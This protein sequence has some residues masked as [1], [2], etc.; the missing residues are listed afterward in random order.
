MLT[1][2]IGALWL[3]TAAEAFAHTPPTVYQN[4]RVDET[5]AVW[6]A[7]IGAELFE[8]WLG[9]APKTLDDLEEEERARVV[10]AVEDFFADWSVLSIDRVP[11]KGVLKGLETMEFIDHMATWRYG[12]VTLVY[13]TIGR[14]R[15]MS[16]VWK[17]F[18]NSIGW[19][20]APIQGEIS[21]FGRGAYFALAEKEPEFVWHV[22]R[23]PRAPP[24]FAPPAA[25]EK[26]VLDLPVASAAL[27]A[28]G[29]LAVPLLLLGKASGKITAGVAVGA[30]VLAAALSGVARTEVS[31]P[32]DRAFEMPDEEGARFLFETIQKNIYRA[33]EYD[34]EEDVYDTLAKSVRGHLLEDV[35]AE[36]MESLIFRE[37]GGG[38]VSRILGT[39]NVETKIEFG[40]SGA[41]AFELE[42]I[43]RVTGRVEH[44]G[45][46][47]T[48][49]N[50]YQARFEVSYAGG[51]WLIS[52]M[53]VLDQKR[54][55]DPE[56]RLPSEMTNPK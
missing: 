40:S 1:A 9:F 20:L 16:I 42:A 43:W 36:V 46:S 11:V 52:K 27:V 8:D 22:P 51:E 31:L 23:E 18:E 10:S 19:Y 29:I 32:W 26:A 13:S 3:L 38:A 47:H 49:L 24:A 21:G 45:H 4:V 25:P 2:A 12:K 50:E 35:Y 30:L 39:E 37:E 33:F 14:P 15:Q 48:R 44:W 41:R 17:R 28:L 53:E 34:K 5:E 7:T 55:E 54:L 56:Y 6:E